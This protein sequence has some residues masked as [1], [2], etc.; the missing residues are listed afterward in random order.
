M[1]AFRGVLLTFTAITVNG[2]IVISK[3]IHFEMNSFSKLC[4]CPR[5]IGLFVPTTVSDGWPEATW[6]N[7]NVSNTPKRS[8]NVV[9]MQWWCYCY[10][11]WPL[12]ILATRS[13][14]KLESVP[15][16]VMVFVCCRVCCQSHY[17]V[18]K[19]KHFRVTGLLTRGIH[20]SPVN[21]PHKGQWRGALVFS[22]I[23]AWINGWVNTGEYGDLRR[24][25]AHYNV[26]VMW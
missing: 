15:C 8:R 13:R 21:S 18:T 24:H 23:F 25:R 2:F 7:N 6:R 4:P 14:R 16:S 10:V 17:D 1:S 11:M 5:L 12:G 19:W 26:T 9:L 20:R 3:W 22:L